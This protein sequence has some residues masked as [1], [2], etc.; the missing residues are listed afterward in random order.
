[1]LWTI[2]APAWQWVVGVAVALWVGKN[3]WN[4]FGT[5]LNTGF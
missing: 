1:M 5:N 3:T 4:T 2:S